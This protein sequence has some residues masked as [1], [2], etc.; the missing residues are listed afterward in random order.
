[1]AMTDTADELR[2]WVGCL[3]CYNA[4]ALVGEWIDATEAE[5]VTVAA[6]HEAQRSEVFRADPYAASHE[7]LWCFDTE[8]F[9]DLLTGEC[10]PSEAQRIAEAVEA[11]DY[12]PVAAIAAYAGDVGVEY[13]LENAEEAWAGQWESREDFAQDYAESIGAIDGEA[14]WPN[15]Y[16]DWTAAARDLFMDYTWHDGG[17]VFRVM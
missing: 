8:G 3:G 15:G 7:E 1:M 13:A 12:V 4:G 17:Y 5:T 14:S 2:V 16:I 10:S 6:L 11:I 9:G